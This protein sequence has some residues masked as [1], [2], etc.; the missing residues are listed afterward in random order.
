MCSLTQAHLGVRL[1]KDGYK[2]IGADWKRQE[3][4]EDHE[5]CDNSMRSRVYSS[6]D[7]SSK[8]TSS[9]DTSSKDTSSK[10][11]EDHEFCDELHEVSCL[12]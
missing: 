10:D 5:F 4:F 9:K 3:Y 12:Q 7:T 6:K 8:D 11:T 1:K 2:V